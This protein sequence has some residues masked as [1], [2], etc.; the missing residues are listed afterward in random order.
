M[1]K[2]KTNDNKR[3]KKIIN[4]HKKTLSTQI[5]EK[6]KSKEK[7]VNVKVKAEEAITYIDKDNTASQNELNL[8][9]TYE[10][11]LL[12]LDDEY[13]NTYEKIVISSMKSEPTVKAFTVDVESIEN[14]LSPLVKTA[15]SGTTSTCS[16]Y[17]GVHEILKLNYY[18]EAKFVKELEKNEPHDEFWVNVEFITDEMNKRLT[19]SGDKF[20]KSIDS[21]ISASPKSPQLLDIRSKIFFN[22]FDVLF[23]NES[24]YCKLRWFKHGR[25]KAKRYCQTKFYIQNSKERKDLPSSTIKRINRLS[26]D[27]RRLFDTLSNLGKNG[28]SDTIAEYTVR[29]ELIPTFKSVLEIVL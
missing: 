26:K 29:R 27:M 16:D 14:N 19:G 8:V 10:N 20:R 6:N 18:K 5:Q 11:K 17:T 22:F 23:P 13:W 2:N 28:T 3:R 24:K 4:N 12:G 25:S 7:L 9:N 15:I 1:S 21:F